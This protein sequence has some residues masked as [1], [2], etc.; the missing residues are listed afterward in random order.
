MPAGHTVCQRRMNPGVRCMKATVDRI[1]EG[2]AVLILVDDQRVAFPVPL[3][4]L[5]DLVE[6]DILEITIR[7]DPVETWI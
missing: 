2:Y 6:G 1:E 4:L 3:D 7:K 5:P